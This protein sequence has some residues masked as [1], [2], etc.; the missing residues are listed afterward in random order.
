[1]VEQTMTR[2]TTTSDV[3]RAN[4]RAATEAVHVTPETMRVLREGLRWAEH[5]EGAFDPALGRIVELWDVAYRTT[6]PEREAVA[7]LAGR[8]SYRALDLDMWRGRPAVRFT[9]DIA[10]DL[11][12]IGK[13]YGVDEAAAVLRDWGIEHLTGLTAKGRELQDKIMA[14]PDRVLRAAEIFER[15]TARLAT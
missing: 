1:M 2:F 12:G 13:G 5:T 3:G 6:P 7:L 10:L 9:Q 11:G 8:G 15:R 4:R 14:L